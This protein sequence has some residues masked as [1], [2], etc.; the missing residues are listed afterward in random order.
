MELKWLV[1]AGGE[2]LLTF[3]NIKKN[4]MAFNSLRDQNKPVVVQPMSTM[5]SVADM[6]CY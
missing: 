5:S 2:A 4:P 1:L 3:Q 6:V